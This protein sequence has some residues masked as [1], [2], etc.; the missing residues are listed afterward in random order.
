MT[1]AAIRTDGGRTLVGDFLF[2]RTFL[3]RPYLTSAA[4]DFLLA[5]GGALLALA[6]FWFYYPLSGGRGISSTDIQATA[7]LFATLSY[8]VNYPHFMASYG[9]LYRNLPARLATYSPRESM[10][11]RMHLAA[12]GV[13]V[14]LV[15]YFTYAISQKSFF[16]FGLAVQAMFFF[17]G[18][19][20]LKQSYGVFAVLSGMKG[21]FYKP[22][23]VILLKLH[24]YTLWLYTWFIS[25]AVMLE[26]S[27]TQPHTFAG[28][29]YQPI[30]LFKTL[31]LVDMLYWPVLACGIAAWGA[32]IWNWVETGKR[33]SVTGLMGYTSMY[34]LLAFVR[35][36]PL[37]AY[38]GP[39]FHSL[40]YMLFVYAYKRG[41]LLGEQ[42]HHAIGMGGEAKPYWLKMLGYFTLICATGA[43]AFE[44]L[45]IYFDTKT[46]RWGMAMVA[47]PIFHV[48]INVHHYFIDSV[49]WRRG[50]RDVSAKLFA[51]T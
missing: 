43:L 39:M 33:P 1:D 51:R 9:L 32:I 50:N 15:A 3:G 6:F 2:G 44:V 41:E 13:P 45:P 26:G 4:G 18:W 42:Q 31:P 34:T 22:W 27:P 48:F 11:W 28:V 17:V 24:V 35:I 36:H 7:T 29:T 47:A 37:F 14:L 12:Y 25:G 23:Q 19:H 20:Y 8:F 46:P 30:S 49:I 10:W 5:G 40:Q 16:L 38:G 21:I